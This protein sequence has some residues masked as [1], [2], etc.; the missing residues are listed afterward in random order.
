M[1]VWGFCGGAVGRMCEEVS[2]QG[3]GVA[4]VWDEEKAWVLR[5]GRGVCQV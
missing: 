3:E 5:I 4:R 1:D 2:S